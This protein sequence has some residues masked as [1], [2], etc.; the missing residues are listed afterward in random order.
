MAERI[1]RCA[2]ALG[3]GFFGNWA[4][5]LGWAGPPERTQQGMRG[6]P[7]DSISPPPPNP[8]FSCCYLLWF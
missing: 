3:F 7:R 1:F 5:A 4:V 8:T 6:G 2:M